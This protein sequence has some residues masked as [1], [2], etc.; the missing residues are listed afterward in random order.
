[1]SIEEDILIQDFIKKTLSEKE[2]NEVLLRLKNDKNFRDKVNFEEQLIFNLNNTDWSI[3]KNSNHPEVKEYEKLLKSDSTNLLKGTLQAVNSEYQLK[4]TNKNKPW[5]LYTGIAVVLVLFGLK[6]FSPF[7][8]LPNELYANYI[9]LSELPS[10]VNRGD[11][12]QKTLIKAQKLFETKAYDK[13]L[14][15]LEKEFTTVQK[16]KAA[17]YLYTGISQM[18]LG[19]FNKAEISFNTLI[20]SKLIDSPKGI[21]YKALLFLKQNEPSKA[22]KMLLQITES[23]NNYKYKEA[24]E[25][26]SKL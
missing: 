20:E 10:L 19:Q 5:L 21:W 16:N 23:S 8:T 17:V 13:S 26:L 7:K 25:I 3:S 15:I 1:M 18:E 9:D 24:S 11:S 2:K 4:Q 22:K 6:V 12:K 14:T